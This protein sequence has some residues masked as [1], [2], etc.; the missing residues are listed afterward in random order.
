MKEKQKKKKKSRNKKPFP[1]FFPDAAHTDVGSQCGSQS[2]INGWKLIL[3]LFDTLVSISEEVFSQLR[4]A[5]FIYACFRGEANSFLLT[6][7]Q[8]LLSWT[9]VLDPHLSHP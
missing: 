5:L 3:Y 2:Q 1:F 4:Y 8:Y 7:R 9:T 6:F